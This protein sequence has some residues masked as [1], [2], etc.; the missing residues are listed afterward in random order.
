VEL[1]K[2]V[3]SLHLNPNSYK[4]NNSLLRTAV[5]DQS[6]CSRTRDMEHLISDPTISAF[7]VQGCP[8]SN[9]MISEGDVDSSSSEQEP[10]VGYR[11][12]S[13]ELY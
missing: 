4:E 12:Q 13:N 3:F 6:Q 10:A 1:L 11:L 9:K 5:I 2:L 7:R 8:T